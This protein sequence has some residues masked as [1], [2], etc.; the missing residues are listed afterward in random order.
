MQALKAWKSSKNWSIGICIKKIFYIFGND[1]FAFK[2]VFP[3]QLR[4]VTP[5]YIITLTGETF[6]RSFHVKHV[7]LT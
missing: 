6:S 1:M 5:V 3:F 4:H 7:L 2:K